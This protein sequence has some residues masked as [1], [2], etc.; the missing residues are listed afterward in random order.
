LKTREENCDQ[1]KEKDHDDNQNQQQKALEEVDGYDI[2]TSI[3]FQQHG[4]ITT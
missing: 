4:M 2:T 3:S 1:K